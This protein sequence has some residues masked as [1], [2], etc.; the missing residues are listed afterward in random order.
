MKPGAVALGPDLMNR[1]M[2]DNSLTELAAGVF[3]PTPGLTELYV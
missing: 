3:N 1:D 2:T